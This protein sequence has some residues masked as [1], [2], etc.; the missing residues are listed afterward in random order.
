MLSVWLPQ[1]S[2]ESSL[3]MAVLK[4]LVCMP[5]LVLVAV[6]PFF[7]FCVR[8]LIYVTTQRCIQRVRLLLWICYGINCVLMT[9]PFMFARMFSMTYFAL[10]VTYSA[11]E[12]CVLVSVSV[13]VIT[14]VMIH[15]CIQQFYLLLLCTCCG[16]NCLITHFP[17]LFEI[18]FSVTLF[19]AFLY[20]CAP[21]LHVVVS[22]LC[23]HAFT[24]RTMYDLFVYNADEC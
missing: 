1:C 13:C 17:F 2:C 9:F 21:E 20:F 6:T 16:I 11:P 12:P 8:L 3:C 22:V 5:L 7:R 23:P 15:C 19:C 4:Q 14:Y 24:Y 18:K 10:S